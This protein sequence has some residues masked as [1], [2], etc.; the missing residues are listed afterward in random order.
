MDTVFLAYLL[1]GALTGFIA[2]LLGVGGGIVIVPMLVL[3]FSLQPQ[4]PHELIM[5]LALGTSMA[6][7]IF[8][9]MSSSWSHHR[10]GAVRWSIVF[11]ISVGIIPGTFFGSCFVACMSTNF[12]RG[13]FVIFLFYVGIQMVRN[14]KPTPSR[15]LPG[16]GGM[17]GVGGVIGVFSSMVGI[18]G[19]TLSIPFMIW[20]NVPMHQAIG[21]SAAIGFFIACA[22]AVGYIVNG[23]HSADLP[24]YAVGYVYLPAL[25]GIIVTSILTAPLGAW[26]ANRWPVPRLKIAFACLLFII[27]IIMAYRLF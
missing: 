14:K 27:G 23:L 12:L 15:D 13:V 11:L 6:T 2:G 18:G 16:W 22:G 25:L 4:I 26:L 21:T 3:C 5:H 8:T 7:I 9:S 20:C 1:T 19:G 10:R 17:F 24:Q